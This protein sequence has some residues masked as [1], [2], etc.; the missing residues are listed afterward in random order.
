MMIREGS[1]MNG[2]IARYASFGAASLLAAALLAAPAFADGLPGKGKT[3]APDAFETRPCT[4]TANIGATTDYV[5]RGFSQTNE[6]PAI[7]GGID[8]T[9]GRFYVGF[10]GSNVDFGPVANVEMDFYGG[11][12]TKTG[13]ISWDF[14][15]IYYAYPGSISAADVDYLEFKVA[16]SGEVWKG[17]TLGATVFYSPEYTFNSGNVWTV[18][19]SFAQALPNVGMFSPTFSAL[20][21]HSAGGSDFENNF[22]LGVD[23]NYTY[24][25]V[26]LTLGFLEKWSIDVRYWD[27]NLDCVAICDSR[28]VGS[29]K[30]TF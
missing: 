5:F 1:K 16:A 2:T 29:L 10:W 15:L 24:W 21:G 17:G 22:L 4:F 7:Q 13:P 6:D 9:C 20:V 19:G 30:Y 3:K 18:E 27:T 11:F 8:A 28:V 25:N 23:D 14:G 26:G 12:K